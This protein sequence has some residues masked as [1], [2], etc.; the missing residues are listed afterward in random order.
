LKKRQK[1]DKEKPEEIGQ[2]L[3]DAVLPGQLSDAP[4]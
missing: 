4:Q 3:E 1:G 2:L